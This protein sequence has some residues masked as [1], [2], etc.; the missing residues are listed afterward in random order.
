MLSTTCLVLLNKVSRLLRSTADQS[1]YAIWR[2]RMSSIEPAL[3]T[4][5]SISPTSRRT[6]AN[7]ASVEAQ[8]AASPSEATK[9]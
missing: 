3:L 7:A 6:L 5:T 1:A 8:S 9:S 4:S 2:K